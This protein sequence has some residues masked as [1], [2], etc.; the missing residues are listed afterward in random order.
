MSRFDTY[1]IGGRTA[2][3]SRYPYFVF[4]QLHNG[5]CGGT[6]ISPTFVISAAHCFY[7]G[8]D[9][10]GTLPLYVK[11]GITDRTDLNQPHAAY[12]AMD[13]FIHPDYDEEL[14]IFDIAI[15]RLNKKPF[16]RKGN[17]VPQVVKF[18]REEQGVQS[19]DLRIIGFGKRVFSRLWPMPSPVLMEADLKK[20]ELDE[21]KMF[22]SEYFGSEELDLDF[23]DQE[24]QVFLIENV[25]KD[26]RV[27]CGFQV[28]SGPCYGDSG[29][30]LL[31]VD[32]SESPENDAQ[33]GIVSFGPH[34]CAHP[35]APSVFTNVQ[36]V[37]QWVSSVLAESNEQLSFLDTKSSNRREGLYSI[38]FL[39]AASVFGI[40]YLRK[41]QSSSNEQEMGDTFEV[42]ENEVIEDQTE[43]E[44]RNLSE[45]IELEQA[46]RDPKIF[47]T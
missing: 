36:K 44:I 29:G 23:E 3:K 4:I 38:S 37:E 26:S 21:C 43:M 10:K 25:L 28:D 17:F 6:L 33:V 30:P 24:Q 12:L 20:V 14:N 2:K 19:T 15:I 41:M 11:I 7:Q 1:I 35:Y 18:I 8:K 34:G 27:W 31:V 5:N 39:A 46:K 42:V 47:E 45:D 13:V 9:T 22:W 32:D 40:I 16:S